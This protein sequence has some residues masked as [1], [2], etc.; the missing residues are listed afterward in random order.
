MLLVDHLSPLDMFRNH[1]LFDFV[2]SVSL[3]YLSEEIFAGFQGDIF[4]IDF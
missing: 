4:K 3:Q 1:F 2:L